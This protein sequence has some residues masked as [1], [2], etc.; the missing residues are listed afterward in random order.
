LARAV[1]SAAL[2]SPAGS[3]APPA[4][5]SRDAMLSFDHE[6]LVALFRGNS[7][8]ALE[9]LRTCAG[10]AV[11]HTRVA[12]GSIDLSQVAPTEYRA[13]A[14]IILHDGADRPVAGVIVE[15]Q[16]HIKRDKLLAW[17][18]YVANLRAQLGCPA[19]L[20]VIAPDPAVAAWA[21]R[22]IE[23][24][25][26]GFY[27][28]PVVIGFD[29]VP[30]VRD[31]VAAS[32]LPE[33]A[34]LS[35][36]AHPELEIAEAAI[37]AIAQLP[38]D[39]AR[40]YFDVIMMALPAA[41]RRILEARMQHYEYRSDFARKY[42]GQGVAEG[43]EKG[44]EQGLEKGLEQGLEK[45]LEQG[46]EKGLEQG[47]ENGLRT[48]VIALAHAKLEALSEDDLTAI[49]AVSDPRV[50]TELVTSLGRASSVLEARATL[51]R[52]L[53]RQDQTQQPATG[54]RGVEVL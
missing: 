4:S 42:Y 19:V 23:L 15:V 52:A 22:P 41:I 26:P 13:D 46:L 12:L 8:L 49:E 48:A 53:A 34:V 47:L 40:L 17:P 25:H 3:P 7:Q 27:L 32:R 1:L 14:V 21:R 2:S 36:L 11:D 30:W 18:A 24:G 28:T 35:V 37:D 5:T 20:L 9:L 29:D 39:Q 45:G 54:S 16:R 6:I 43:L 50:L 38:A 51:D 10:I 31:A 33:L 44:L